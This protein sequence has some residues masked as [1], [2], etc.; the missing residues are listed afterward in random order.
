M[1]SLERLGLEAFGV[2]ALCGLFF[3]WWALHNHTEQKIG[4]QACIQSTTEVRADA[5]RD[6]SDIEAAHAA[7]LG[8]VVA[9]YDQKLQDSANANAGLAG[10]LLYDQIRAG[11]V[12]RVAA[13]AARALGTTGKSSEA[14]GASTANDPFGITSATQDYIN[15]CS[16]DARALNALQDAWRSQLLK[17]ATP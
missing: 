12:R 15:A 5:V 8:K 6:D 14:A 7:Q 16:A 11:T 1:T 17:S 3:A 2:V 13:A 9:I 4:A 10:R